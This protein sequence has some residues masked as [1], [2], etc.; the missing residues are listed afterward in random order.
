VDGST[1]EIETGKN[2]GIVDMRPAAAKDLS[3]DFQ[4]TYLY[5]RFDLH[6]PYPYDGCKTLA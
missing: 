6:S 2:D 3:L 1:L 5:E 4:K